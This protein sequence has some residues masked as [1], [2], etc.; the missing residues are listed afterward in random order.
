M[1]SYNPDQYTEQQSGLTPEESFDELY[2]LFLQWVSPPLK[3]SQPADR[4]IRLWEQFKKE[5]GLP[6]ILR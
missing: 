5:R 2:K 1:S 3:S 4:T 6:A